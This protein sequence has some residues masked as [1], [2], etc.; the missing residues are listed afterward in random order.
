VAEDRAPRIGAGAVSRYVLPTAV[1]KIQYQTLDDYGL[2]KI[3]LHQTIRHP[4]A[5]QV[6]SSTTIATLADH[7]RSHGGD[8]KMALKPLKLVKGDRVTIALEAVDY[9]GDSPG[10]STT[11]DPVT[12]LV[13]DEQG[14]LEAMRR[15]DDR[16]VEKLNEI[17]K[18]QLGIGE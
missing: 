15:F 13:T 11:S 7:P 16:T 18:A 4:D 10:R 2:S 5:D 8:H 3:V 1:P 9:R 14:L 12:F 6:E 17:I